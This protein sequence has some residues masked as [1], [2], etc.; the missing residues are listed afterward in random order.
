MSQAI[1]HVILSMGFSAKVDMSTGGPGPN[2][3][4]QYTAVKLTTTAWQVDLA[5]TAKA[6]GI[7]NN[8]PK[9]NSAAE[10]VL[11]GISPMVVDGNAGAIAPGDRLKTDSSGRGIKT[12]TNLDE[13]IATAL[14][15]S[16]AQNDV[17][18][19]LVRAGQ[20]SS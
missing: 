1:K 10:V 12:V 6:I 20:I 5:G 18:S 2:S 9:I 19:V 11:E 17:I 4:Y 7:L 8:Q 3:S 15:P 13:Y 16:T 14:E